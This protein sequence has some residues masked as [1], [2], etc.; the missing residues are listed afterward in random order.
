MSTQNPGGTPLTP[1]TTRM[2]AE[3]LGFTFREMMEGSFALGSTDPAAGAKAGD[4]AGTKLTMRATISIHDLDRFLGESA[5]PGSIVGQVDF[6]PLGMAMPSTKGV[7]NLFRPA[8]EPGMKYMVYE[9]GFESGGKPYY[10]AGKKHV[11]E[12]SLL[13]LWKDTTTLYTLLHEGTDA[14]GP[15]VGAGI[16]SLSMPELLK[17][18]PTMHALNARNPKEEIEAASRFGRFFLGELYDT[19]I[20]H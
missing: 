3:T 11:R 6:A 13:E 16:I 5:H 15:V 4:K 2:P 10:M 7:F 14:S 12:H 1:D 20:K 9:L 8:A 18:I 19:Y 17:M